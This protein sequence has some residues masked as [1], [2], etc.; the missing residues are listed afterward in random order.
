ML[1]TVDYRVEYRAQTVVEVQAAKDALRKHAITTIGLPKDNEPL[2]VS[3]M[4]DD[5]LIGNATGKFSWNWLYIDLLWVGEAFRKR[6]VGRELMRLAEAE[7]R[8]KKVTG[9]YLWTQSWQAPGFYTKLGYEQ[10]VELKDFPPG[11][12]R[13][14]FCKY[15][16]A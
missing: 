9:I 11:H 3:A 1:A 10:F 6:G 4:T 14:G 5:R 12:T 16:K 7:A 15:L 2:F 13:I 8:A